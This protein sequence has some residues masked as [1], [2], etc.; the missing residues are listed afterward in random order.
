MEYRKLISFGKNSFVVSLPKAWVIQNKLKKGDSIYIDESSHNLV[1]QPRPQ[2]EPEEKE[3]TITI[4]GKD[5]RRIQREL[6][7]AYIQNYKLIT[8]TG[9]EIKDKAKK[10]QGF[11][12]NLVALEILEQ[13]SKKVVA[14]DF[15]NLNDISIEQI[16]R[17]MDIIT[18]SM[19]KDCKTMFV[20]DNYENIYNRDNDVNKF[21][22]LI[23]RIVWFGMENP[24]AVLKKL[25]LK[26]R[27]LFNLW[28]LSFSLESIADY[29]KRIA[30]YMKDVKLI[31]KEQKEFITLLE[32]LEIMFSD[33]MKAYYTNNVE[34]AHQ[35]V[36]NRF[37]IIQQFD[38]FYQRNRNVYLIGYLIYNT[39]S[40]AVAIHSIGRIVYQGMPG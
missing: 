19:I 39:K 29:T 6:I 15:L 1:L 25:S 10:I 20:E 13:D 4:D 40:L 32:Q 21:R 5:I 12:Q 9:I 3:I 27:D 34:L 28:W 37:D 31:P 23:Y 35:V 22:F 26:Q 17:K 33:S 30:R 16:L 38:D 36:Q 11:V 2:A 24:S 14:K 7:A 18:R 8:L